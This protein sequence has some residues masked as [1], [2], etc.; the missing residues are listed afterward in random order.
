[1]CSLCDVIQV[2]PA[3]FPHVAHGLIRDMLRGSEHLI[4][5]PPGPPGVPGQNTWVSSRDN[6]VDIVDYIKCKLIEIITF[7]FKLPSD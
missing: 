4:R 6:A 1:M 5:G 2:L 7:F 3:C